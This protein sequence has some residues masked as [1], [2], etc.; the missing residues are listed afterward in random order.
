MSIFTSIHIVLGF[1]FCSSFDYEF[2]W[3]AS[4]VFQRQLSAIQSCESVF[5]CDFSVQFH[6][7]F[8][9]CWTSA[10][11]GGFVLLH[12]TPY[13]NL[14]NSKPRFKNSA[15]IFAPLLVQYN[16]AVVICTVIYMCC[17]YHVWLIF[18]VS[19]SV[20]RVNRSK[21]GPRISQRRLRSKGLCEWQ[22]L[23]FEEKNKIRTK[24]ITVPCLKRI[25]RFFMFYT[26]K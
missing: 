11:K 17:A 25:F 18:Y 24:P 1:S 4:I 12:S 3:S 10:L 14:T 8:R 22:S 7:R 21:T 2:R 13:S 23:E 6:S 15:D 26:L 19:S 5:V 9:R 20:K 16:F